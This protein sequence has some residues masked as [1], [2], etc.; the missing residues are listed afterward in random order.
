MFTTSSHSYRE[1]LSLGLKPDPKLSVS[2]WADQYRILPVKATREAGPWRT[3]RTPYLREIMDSLAPSDPTETV[4]LMK[5]TQVGGTECGNNWLGYV[6]HHTPGP[7]MMVLPTLEMAKRTSKQRIA[8]MIEAM[9][10]L[11][12]RIKD[13]RSRDS[14][15]TQ[16]VKEFPNGVLIMTGANSATGLRSMP[17]RFL[18]LDE[19]DAFDDDVDGEGNP[20]NLAIKRTSTFSGSRKILLVSTPNI[21]GESKIEK[22]FEDSDQRYFY[23]PCLKCGSYQV[24]TWEKIKFDNHDPASARFVCEACDH[25][26]HEHD[27]PQLLAQG[28]WRPTAEGNGRNRGYHLSSLYSPNGWYSWAN[29]VEDF[30]KSKDDPTLLKDWTNTVM[31]QTFQEKGETVDEQS[32]YLRREHYQHEVPIQ[33]EILTAGI[34]VQDDRFEVE[35]VGWGAREES[36]SIDYIRLY[37]DLSRPGIWQQLADRLR[38]SYQR[39]D[40]VLMNIAMVCM[41]S[42]HYTD[43]VYQFSRNNGLLWVVPIKGSSLSGKPVAAFPRKRNKKGVYL[44]MVGTD[45]CKEVIYQRYRITNPGFGYCHWPIRDVYDEDYFAQATAEE[46]LTKYRNGVPYVIWDA[47]RRRNEA[48]DCRIY[49]FVAIRILQQHRNVNLERLAEQRRNE[50]EQID[51]AYTVNNAKPAV[52]HTP[53]QQPQRP[54]RKRR[55]TR[56][57]YLSQ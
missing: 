52:E 49:A 16:L 14:G 46:R 51:S 53:I 37:G 28:E 34:D 17:A 1:G 29:A 19:I 35:V 41:D 15:N 50:I 47:K 22:A 26:M 9:P 33:V 54:T 40:G 11:S 23:L 2:Q 10:V 42:G 18:F 57:R 12:E 36:W 5:G 39:G 55:Q 31:G 6:V 32:L 13:P 43:E 38:Q 45:T 30:L 24:L 20:I 48:L 7:M 25:E 56:S 4:V 8:P 3:D 44:T 21:A 27:K